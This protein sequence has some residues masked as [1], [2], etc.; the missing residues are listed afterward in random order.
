MVDATMHV[1]NAEARWSDFASDE[2]RRHNYATLHPED[3]EIIERVSHFFIRAFG[4]RPRAQRAI[5]VGSGSN[6]YPALLM[7]PWT[8]KV[9]LTDFSDRNVGWLRENVWR[10]G[11]RWDWQPFWHELSGREGYNQVSEP[12]KQLKLACASNPGLAGIERYSIF[13]LPPGR[14]QLGTMFFVAESITSE[15]EEFNA[16]VARFVGALQPG[17]P[18]AAAFMKDSAGYEVS[19]ISFPALRVSPDDV[20]KCFSDLGA[21]DLN[22]YLNETQ[23]RV[24]EGYEGMIVA[25]G[26]VGGR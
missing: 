17:S 21:T 8:E 11:A 1:R 14:W 5:D 24:R 26:I 4:T 25:T 16:A 20:T 10:D 2:Y 19:G 3:R 6:L 22:V 9:L 23:D 18:F 12:R 15:A 7:L 13:D